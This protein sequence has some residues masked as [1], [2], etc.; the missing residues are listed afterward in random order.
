MS[1]VLLTPEQQE[2]LLRQKILHVFETYPTISNSMLQIS[3]GSSIPTAI[4]KPILEKL[5]Q[6]E[7]LFRY[8]KRVTA[9]NSRLQTVTILSSIAPPADVVDANQHQ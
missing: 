6:E 1:E 4:W 9:P 2:E 8:S 3:L 7:K 5:I